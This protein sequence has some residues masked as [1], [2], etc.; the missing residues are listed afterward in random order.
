MVARGRKGPREF[1][2]RSVAE[3]YYLVGYAL[4]ILSQVS[5]SF[6]V[7]RMATEI[8]WRF[9]YGISLPGNLFRKLQMGWVMTTVI[10]WPMDRAVDEIDS[11]KAV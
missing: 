11:K 4:Y 8:L 6:N 10:C 1:R 9:K 3:A 2:Q 7:K 5:L